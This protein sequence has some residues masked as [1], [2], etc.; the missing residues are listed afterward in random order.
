[1][2]TTVKVCEKCGERFVTGGLGI[3]YQRTCGSPSCSE[4]VVYAESR[5][6]EER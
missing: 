4:P 5:A 3:V 1:M 2:S 6:K